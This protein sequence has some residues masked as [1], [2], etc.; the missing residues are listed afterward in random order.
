MATARVDA[1]A[2]RRILRGRG[3]RVKS[4]T[5]LLAAVA[6][7]LAACGG[8]DGSSAETLP[9]L[10]AISK[11]DYVVHEAERGAFPLV[12]KGVATPIVVDADD[13]APVVRVVGDLQADVQRVTGVQPAVA[14][15][16]PA[17]AKKVILVGTLG[18]SAL[19]DALVAED[20]LDVSAIQGKWET[21]LIQPVERPMAG[22]DRALVVVGADKR[23]A[24]YGAYDVSRNIG[25]SPWYWWDD[26]TPE[27][28]DTLY[29][30]YGRWS[31]GTPAVQFRGFFIN[32]ENP[33][34]GRWALKTFGPGKGVIEKP[35]CDASGC[36]WA[37]L[38]Y[39]GGLV[40][41]Y[42]EKVFEVALR[43]RA[44]YFWPAVWGRQFAYDD[45]ENLDTVARYGIVYG[46]S[47]EAPMGR[48]I[49]E[50]NQQ[51]YKAVRDS[52]GNITQAGTDAWGGTGEWSFV[53]N[54]EALKAYWTEGIQ[55]IKEKGLDAVVTMAMRG[56]GDFPPTD[57]AAGKTVMEDVLAAQRQ[58]LVDVLG[59]Q[60][61]A[62][63]P[64]VWLLYKEVQTYWDEAQGALR[65]PEDVTVV[66][67]DDNWS[68][69]RKLQSPDEPARSGGYG[70]YYHFDYVGA[71]RNYKWID[72]QL[73]PNVWEQLH[74]VHSYGVD[75]LWVVNVGDMKNEEVPLQ[76]FLDYAW[77]P[78]AIPVDEL[79]GWERRWAKQQFGAA[80]AEAIAEVLHA[81]AKLQSDR[82]PELL[83]R[84]NWLDEAGNAR[85]S[86]QVYFASGAAGARTYYDMN[87]FSLT[88]YRE[89]E[90]VVDQWL[91]LADQVEAIKA[92]LPADKR[93][94]FFELVEYE[95]KA[96]ANLYALRL[97]E[98]K[99]ILYA[100]Q[101][102]ISTPEWAAVA[103]AR[104]ADDQALADHYNEELA[105]G[106][107]WG[108]Q[109]Q[110]KIDY[111]D[112]DRYGGN[113]PWQQPELNNDAIAD[114]IFPP[115]LW[116]DFTSH[117]K[118]M[119]V[120]V[121]GAPL[122]FDGAGATSHWT[123]G[124][125]VA[126]PTFSPH[127]TQPA[128]WIEVF[129]RG[130]SS[131][132][133][134]IDAPEWITV[135]LEPDVAFLDGYTKEARATLTVNDWAAAEDATITVTGNGQTVTIPVVVDRPA[136]PASFTGF[137]EANGYVS[138]NADHYSRKVD[139]T[140]V[141]WTLLPDIG[142]TGNGVTPFPVT[143]AAVEPGGASPRLEYDVL[144]T[145]PDVEAVKINVYVS[146]RNNVR[147]DA[148]LNAAANGAVAVLGDGLRYAVS[149]D[150]GDP[151]VVDINVG[152]DDIFLN[153]IWGRNT[154]NNVNLTTTELAVSGPG[155]HTVKVWMVDPGVIF[156]K[157][158]VDTE[159][160]E[161]AQSYFGPPESLQVQ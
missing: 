93:D 23:G 92:Q 129:S 14:H 138:M 108:W 143:A 40:K 97:A 7:G 141:A 26:V 84:R 24:I 5:A 44:N 121:D 50:W 90:L 3:L 47:H 36:T 120:T 34:T 127:Q 1:S 89:M 115:V 156:Q 83:N 118:E 98:F 106:K 157:V 147:R 54:P 135:A 85:T 75:R 95:V 28:Q 77:D 142:R 66:W 112:Q 42:W 131:F 99:N 122:P 152:A 63:I 17:G 35:T 158:V 101:G 51:S 148:V 53:R 9:P 48:G 39:P 25:V 43:L 134:Q 125:T 16:V 61:A 161:L 88:H 145:S 6:G 79:G 94:A 12:V 139:A 71:D 109:T 27:H 19:I 146:P 144:V 117:A 37:P 87:P 31:Q 67:C 15:A 73:L 116:T 140:P 13:L 102:R 159:T 104:F 103:Q 72:T 55:R 149:V 68:N 18:H 124:E 21:F 150:D 20:K 4:L 49:E 105:G 113:A 65:P 62:A 41:E 64:K 155:V 69:M 130:Q 91:V 81:Y 137:V 46:T 82:K 59:E 32:D 154:S 29:V 22:V 160:G 74:L 8:G 107:W 96:T 11:A 100:A 133:F 60:Q 110:P 119:G 30:K 80:Q 132:S 33:Q 76:F 123:T 151:Q 57:F 128:Q 136:V 45:P 58:I 78:S 114:A 56:Q 2:R 111:G 52:D 10:G 126:L 153:G 38:A 70:I 86:D